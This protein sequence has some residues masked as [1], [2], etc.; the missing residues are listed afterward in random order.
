MALITQ[1]GHYLGMTIGHLDEELALLEGAHERFLA[2]DMLAVLHG[3]HHYE[4]VRMV[5][6]A[7][8]NGIKVVGILLE[9]LAEVGIALGVGVLGEHLLALL[10]LQ[11]NVAQGHHIYHV[12]LGKLVDVLLT[13]VSDAYVGNLHLLSLGVL[14]LLAGHCK[15]VSRGQS[16]PGCS[17]AHSLQEISS[18]GHTVMF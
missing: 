12:G 4:E 3:H 9:K 6:G 17:Q 18:C 5:G 1:L 13:A 15:H 7:H 14:G 2:I 11:V 10:A 16:Q 8:R